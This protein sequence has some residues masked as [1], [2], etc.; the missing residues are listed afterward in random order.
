MKLT[1]LTRYGVLSHDA[2]IVL[3]E[4]SE[5]FDRLGLQIV[6][7]RAPYSVPA[8]DIWEVERAWLDNDAP[9]EV[10][11]ARMEE[12]RGAEAR[13]PITCQWEKVEL[14]LRQYSPSE[15]LPRDVLE[16]AFYL[17]KDVRGYLREMGDHPEVVEINRKLEAL[18]TG[19]EVTP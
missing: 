2:Q 11:Q 4:L 1:D 15:E 19:E 13:W 10:R 8:D 3:D 18:M 7:S 9:P 6:T 5:L 14:L 12:V 16:Q 17:L